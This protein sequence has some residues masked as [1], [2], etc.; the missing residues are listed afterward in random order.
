MNYVIVW[1]EWTHCSHVYHTEE[2]S[3][4]VEA[5][6]RFADLSSYRNKPGDGRYVVH[7]YHGVPLQWDWAYV[8]ET[9]NFELKETPA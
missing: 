8:P 2:F 9:G 3:D 4:V 7:T 1:I 5:R 6:L